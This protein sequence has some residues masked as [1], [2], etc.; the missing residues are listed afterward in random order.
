MKRGGPSPFAGTVRLVRPLLDVP[1]L[2]LEAFACRHKIPFSEDASNASLDIQRNRI[3]LELLPLLRQHYQPALERTILRHMELARGDSDFVEETASRWLAKLRRR[4]FGS[5]PVAVQRR[6][7]QDQ[8]FEQGQPVDFDLV[9]HLRTRPDEAISTG[10]GRCLVRGADGLVGRRN[11]KGTGFRAG[12]VWLKL[13]GR[14]GEAP[15]E[16]VK[17][18]WE[19]TDKTGMKYSPRTNQE[20]FDADKVGPRIR[21][22]HWR[23]GDRFQ[24]IGA[25]S[26][27]KLQDLFTNAKVPRAER[28]Q[29]LLGATEGGRIFWVEGLRIAE[30]FKLEQTTRRRLRWS[31]R[32]TAELRQTGARQSGIAGFGGA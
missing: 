25:G 27:V 13:K 32:R 28:R 4:S 19:L 31:W 7:I 15:F 16:G 14:R 5:L 1:K 30:G 17:F 3:R 9:E 8:L 18:N 29:R 26:E 24:P 21:V 2:Q 10:P 20:E 23:A 6:V 22:R 11:E 12:S